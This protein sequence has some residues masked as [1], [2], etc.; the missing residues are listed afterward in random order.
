MTLDHPGGPTVVIKSQRWRQKKRCGSHRGAATLVA[1]ETEE[2]GATSQ[3]TQARLEAGKGKE[4]GVPR[5]LDSS[6]TGSC[7]TVTCRSEAVNERCLSHQAVVLCYSSDVTADI[8]TRYSSRGSGIIGFQQ[9]CRGDGLMS[10]W[11]TARRLS[12]AGAGVPVPAQD[13]VLCVVAASPPG[14]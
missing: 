6:P 13:P 11:V 9:V 10:P 2:G 12:G 3:G 8:Q 4:R 5:S 14:Q 1:L 7:C